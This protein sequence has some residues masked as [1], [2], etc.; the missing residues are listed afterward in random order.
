MQ[1]RRRTDEE[2]KL[3][4]AAKLLRSWKKFH[5]EEK[6]AA[7]AGPHGAALAELFRMADN[8]NCVHPTQLVGF[9]RAVDWAP[10]PYD[11]RVAV[12][13][14]LNAAITKFR[15]RRGL[16]PIDDNLPGEPDNAFRVIRQIVEVPPSRSLPRDSRCRTERRAR[17]WP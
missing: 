4:D 6:A 3:A 13:H 1:R 16:A 14:E 12:L 11:M 10:I 7:L 5:A 15:E 2:K 17:Q 8:L 9:V